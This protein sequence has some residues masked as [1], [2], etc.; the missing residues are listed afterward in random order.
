MR[1]QRLIYRTFSG[2]V[3]GAYAHIMEL[4]NSGGHY[5]MGGAPG[6]LADAIDYAPNFVYQSILAIEFLIDR[7]SREDLLPAIKV[8]RAEV[9]TNCDVLPSVSS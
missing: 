2:Y 1:T 3:H 4:H 5:H 8:L 9:A 6:H 7:T